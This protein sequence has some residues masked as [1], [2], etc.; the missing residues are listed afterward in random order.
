MVGKRTLR[1]CARGHQYNK[2]SD[3][4]VCPICASQDKATEGFLSLLVAPAQRALLNNG[5]TS[6]EQLSQF[7]EKEVLSFHGM[8]KT[9]IPK[10]RVALEAAGLSFRID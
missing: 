6:L 3:C 8:G 1:T 4:P 2:I 10:L 7:T 5:I 9:S